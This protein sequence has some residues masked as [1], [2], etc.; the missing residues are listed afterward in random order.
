MPSSKPE[1]TK[2]AGAPLCPIHN[3]AMKVSSARPGTYYC[4]AKD[5]SGA[6]CK[7]KA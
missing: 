2:A 4:T 1:P 5:D 7:H 3:K 6:Y